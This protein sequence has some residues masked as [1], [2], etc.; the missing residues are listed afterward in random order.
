MDL[1]WQ[2][3]GAMLGVAGAIAYLVCRLLRGA[4]P[5]GCGDCSSCPVREEERALI[6][7]EPL[8]SAS[9]QEAGPENP[10]PAGEQTR[11]QCVRTRYGSA[12]E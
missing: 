2:N 8:R 6:S 3:V 1:G 9:A 10:R 4:K 12:E 5:V 7:I 11:A